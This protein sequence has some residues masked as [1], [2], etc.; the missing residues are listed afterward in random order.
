MW[1]G[2]G[3]FFLSERVRENVGFGCGVGR[4][5]SYIECD[6]GVLVIIQLSSHGVF[7]SSP[8]PPFI[9]N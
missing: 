3:A 5:I 6:V 7:Y 9:K 2:G 4:R 1:C 8:P